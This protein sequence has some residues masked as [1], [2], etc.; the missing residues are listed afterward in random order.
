MQAPLAEREVHVWFAQLDA[1]AESPHAAVLDQDERARASRLRDPADRRRYVAAHALA[2]VLLSGYLGE[3]PERLRFRVGPRGKPEL[4]A[5]GG[6]HA[7]SFN[8]SHTRRGAAMALARSMP[9]GVDVEQFDPVVDADGMARL[10]LSASEQSTLAA[11]TPAKRRRAFLQAWV[12]KEAVLKAAGCGLGDGV[13]RIELPRDVL[14]GG[15]DGAGD[16][17]DFVAQ[18]EGSWRVR[19]LTPARD[20][21]GAVAAPDG[22]WTLRCFACE[23]AGP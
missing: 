10:V 2:R 19:S 9:V 17:F 12:C 22:D 14:A 4:V 18:Y 11:L 3:A 23:A 21:L 1:A 15:S 5:E 20:C 6:A 16:G 7:L 13:K 8:L